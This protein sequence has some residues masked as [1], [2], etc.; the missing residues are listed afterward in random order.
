MMQ[1]NLERRVF[2]Q[3]HWLA[4]NQGKILAISRLERSHL[5]SE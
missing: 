3:E 2:F 5:E 1:D 4:V